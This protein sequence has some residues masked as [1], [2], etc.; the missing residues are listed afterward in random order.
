MNTVK[1]QIES[2]LDYMKKSFPELTERAKKIILKEAQRLQF[3][4]KDEIVESAEDITEL[5]SAT[6]I[7]VKKSPDSFNVT[8][9]GD[10]F[11]LVVK[12]MEFGSN[13]RKASK[14]IWVALRRYETGE[15]K[16]LF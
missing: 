11:D 16:E 14:P 10:K 3:L 6:K 12:R 13:V 15:L 1:V 7:V 4:I 9:K 2:P 5:D 8:T